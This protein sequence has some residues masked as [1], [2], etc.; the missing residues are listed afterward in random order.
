MNLVISDLLS[1]EERQ[2]LLSAQQNPE[3]FVVLAQY[4]ADVAMG[5]GRGGDGS[6]MVVM[7]MVFGI[8][9]SVMPINP[10]GVLNIDGSQRADSRLQEGLPLPPQ[11]RILA[12]K[13]LLAVEVQKQ[14][15]AEAEKRR[16]DLEENPLPAFGSLGGW[17]V[18][19]DPTDPSAA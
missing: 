4:V 13:T 11:V 9:Y 18:T 14:I 16:K 8:P 7:Q 10:S 15:E 12:A 17:N 19:D 2:T 1:P 6:P 5:I 3:D